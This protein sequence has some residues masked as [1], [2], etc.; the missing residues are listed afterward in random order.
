M[1]LLRSKTM[2]LFHH[3]GLTETQKQ[4]SALNILELKEGRSRLESFPRRIVLELTNACNLR[5]IMC[6]RDANKFQ[7][8]FFDLN[9]LDRL[10]PLFNIA[11]E[12][13][14][15]GW[16]EPTIHPKFKDILKYLSSYPVKKYFVTNGTTLRSLHDAIFD[17]KI[18]LFA[19]SVDGAKPETNNRIR[20]NSDLLQ[21]IDGLKRILS[22]KKERGLTYPYINFVMTLMRSNLEELPLLVD[23]AASIGVNEVKGV[24]LTSFTESL[25]GE[26]LWNDV[27]RIRAVFKETER[28]GVAAGINIKLPYIQGEDIAEK[29]YHKECFVSWRDFF[30]GS[31]GSVRPCQSNSR[32]LFDFS[33]Y[34]SFEEAWNSEELSSFRKVVNDPKDMWDECK[35]CYQSSH[36]NWNMES[37][38]LQIGNTFAPK[39]EKDK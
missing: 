1:S 7:N 22:T 39:W 33:R 28:R 17:Y 18:D 30:I 24:Y 27:D 37:S 11:E 21:I 10:H 25:K 15:F 12:V 35:R 29:R 9:I 13:V 32:K 36:A 5:C 8:T 38:F 3:D 6:G 26:V 23:V 2:E 4:N 31:D 19:V 20:V 14:L 16:G 34:A